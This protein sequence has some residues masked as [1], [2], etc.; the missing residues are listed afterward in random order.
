[1]TIEETLICYADKFYSKTN[2]GSPSAK[3][4]PEVARH[5]Q[6]YG[7]RQ[8]ATFIRWAARFEDVVLDPDAL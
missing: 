7:R 2:G 1:V 4:I 8:V 6:K 5:L 3:T